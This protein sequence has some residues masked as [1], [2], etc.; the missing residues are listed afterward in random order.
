M[1][2]AA[3]VAPHG[4]HTPCRI[5]P[6]VDREEWDA[7][8][9]SLPAPH[10]PQ[11]W[12]YGEAKRAEGWDVDRLLFESAGQPLALCQVLVKRVLGLPVAAR[13]NRGPQFLVPASAIEQ[14]CEVYKALRRRWRIGRR[15]LLL[16]A[17]GL[18][19]GEAQHRL[20]RQAGFRPRG[21][22]G[23]CSAVLDLRRDDA[24]LRAGLAANWRNHLKVSERGGLVFDMSTS[25]DARAWMLA[26]H[27][28]HMAEKG[29]SGTSVVF[30][31][32]LQRQAPGDFFVCRA[33]LEGEPVAGMIVVRFARSAE[34]F[35]GWYG[36][37]ARRSK[38]GNF[39][40]WNAAQAMREQGCER[41]DLGGYSSSDGYGRFKQDMRGGEYR[42]LE[43]WMCF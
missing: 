34:Y 30:L 15:G 41:F 43:E 39:L 27:A 22:A 33:L 20:M 28:E 24:A 42:L 11:C 35:V 21:V 29:F 10:L 31:Q 2:H 3:F 40:L 38:A 12:A 8:Y 37:E 13:I 4:A 25:E 18:E 19:D 7:L 5:R 26:R 6:V 17:P 1:H 32:A 14:R 16:L 36:P 23:W 9:A